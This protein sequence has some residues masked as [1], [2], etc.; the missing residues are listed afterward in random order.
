MRSDGLKLHLLKGRI[1]LGITKNFFSERVA[2]HWHRLPREVMES[3]YLVA[4]N[5]HGDVTQWG[6]VWGCGGVG[7]GLHLGILVAF[8][9]LNDAMITEEQVQFSGPSEIFGYYY[10]QGSL[11]SAVSFG[12]CDKPNSKQEFFFFFF[13]V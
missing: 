9:S 8:F 10:M 3:L 4:L 5:N 1:R 13:K 7:L 12:Y 2:V 11:A 6:V